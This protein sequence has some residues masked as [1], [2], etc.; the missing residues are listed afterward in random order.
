[1]TVIERMI[2]RWEDPEAFTKYI[3]FRN[4]D[5]EKI[6]P[7]GVNVVKATKCC[8]IGNW[9]LSTGA[10]RDCKEDEEIYIKFR[11]SGLFAKMCKYWSEEDGG[12]PIDYIIE[13]AINLNDENDLDTVLGFLEELKNG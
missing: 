2:K 5:N 4:K 8:L 13:D 10:W 12:D 3:L 6:S 1:M 9:A 7:Y 11:E